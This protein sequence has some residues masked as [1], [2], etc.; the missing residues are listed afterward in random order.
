M[1][2]GGRR[3]E[4]RSDLVLG[5]GPEPPKYA[6]V[7]SQASSLRFYTQYQEYKRST[8]I[9][10]S[11]Q[12][13]T[14]PLLSVTQLLPV[15]IR[16]CLSRTYFNGDE[17][18]AD[19]LW[20]ALAKHAECW[21]DDTVDH[22]IA[23]AEVARLVRMGNER[24][25][26]D[27]VDAAQSRLETYFEN[28]SV[29]RVFRDKTQYK[30][31]PASI[32]SKSLV[33][34]LRPPE[35]KVKVQHELDMRS[36]WKDKPDDVF[37]VVRAA[38]LDWRTVELADKRRSD[39]NGGTAGSAA[40]K[41]SSRDSRKEKP[42]S[43]GGTPASA[44]LVTCFE[45]KKPGHV[46]RNCPLT[47]FPAKPSSQ[48]APGGGNTARGASAGR[49]AQQQQ[50]QRSSSQGGQRPPT[51]ST[52]GQHGSQVS[53]AGRGYG[54]ASASTGFH[55][56]QVAGRAVFSGD[57]GA[58]G[59][60]S[61][62]DSL[63]PPAPFPS[64][65]TAP[66]AL[67]AS[68]HPP[69]PDGGFV[70]A[71]RGVKPGGMCAFE[72][73]G[74]AVDAHEK[75]CRASLSVPGAADMVA[76]DAVAV[77]DSGSGLTTMSV[78]VARK[79]QEAYP[80]VRI[81]E[82]MH[83]PGKLKVA[84]GRVREVTEKTIP[85][86]IALHTSWG[87][88][89]LDPFSFAVMPGDDDVLILGNPTLK[90]L[91][92]DVYDS[93][94]ATAREQAKFTGVETA[95]YKQC[96][97]VVLS[98]DAL[99]QKEDLQTDVPD[100]AVERLIA[101]GPDMCMTSDE[102]TTGRAA[103]LE[104]AVSAAD[105]AGLDE[106]Y[107]ERL[108]GIIRG[109]WN[110]FRR[111]L[112]QGDPPARV[113]PLKVTLTSDARP[114]KARPRVYNPVKTAWLASCMASLVALGL[115]FFNMQAVW[116]SAALVI[117]KKAGFRLVS[118]YRQVNAQVE[119]VPAV[120]PNQEAS[121]AKLSEARFYGS[122]DMLQ[123]YWQ[124]PLAPEA[125]EIFTIATPEGLFTP[126]RVPQGILN[127]TSF[128]QATL[129]QVLAGLNCMVWVD[130]VVYW[131]VDEDDLLDTLDK[132]LARLEE[133]GMFVAAHKCT[134]FETSITWCGKVYSQGEVK[135]DSDRL[136]GLA[137]MRRPE[138]AGE[139][140]QFL[141]AVNW[142]RTSLPRMAEVVWPLRVFLEEQMA[143][144]R[145]RTKRVAQNRAI[146]TAAWTPER[147]AAWDA[148]QALVASAVTLSHP[149]ADCVVLMFPDASDQHYGSFLT[150]VPED[151]VC[152]C[153]PV[154]DMTHEP[155]GFLSGTFR[156][157]Q[158]RWATVDK[159]G[160]A[161]VSTFK[162]LEYLLWNGVHIYTDHRN[163]AYIFDPE[164]CVSSVAKTRAQRLDQWKAVLGQ[165]S[166]TIM[167]IEGERNCWGDL[168]SRWVDVPSV[169]VR[170]VAVYA[171]SEPDDALPSKESIRDAQRAS[172]A[173][174]GSLA[175][176]A[177]SF[178]AESGKVALDGEGLFR[179]HLDGRDV[180][181]IPEDAKK[182]QTRLMVCAHMKD[183]GH[184]GTV[185]TLHRLSEYCCWFRMEEHVTE[186]VKQCLHCMDSKAGEKVPRPLGETVHGTRPGEVVHVDYLFVGE[187]GPLGGDGLDEDDGYKYILV[188]LDDMSNWVWLE[189]TGACTARVTAQHLMAWCKTLGVPE[190]F[191]SDTASHFKNHMMAALEKSLGI[192]RKF[193]VANSPWSN[194]T[195]ERMMREVV[196][197]LK[198]MLQE[199]RRSTRDWVDLV[200]A[201]QWALNTA[202]RERYGS[203][204][205][206][207]MFGRA[208]RIVFLTLASSTE[209]EWQ[210]DVL[211]G[212]A[213][214]RQVRGVVEAQANLHKEVLEKVQANRG[215]Q[216]A[217]ATKGTLPNF[218]VGDYVLVARVRRSGSTPKL[219]MT[220]TGPWR[221]VVA[222]HPHVYGVQNIVSGEVRDVHV[223]RLRFYAD[224]ALAITAEVK[225]V[226]QHAFT[227][228]EFEMAAIVDMSEA[229]DGPGF[230]VEVE[231][232]GF[233]KS[234]NTWEALSKIWDAS[235]QFV[236]SELRKLGLKKAVRAQ[237]KAQ[238]GI[239]L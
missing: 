54:G 82:G 62:E 207:V 220:W 208:P 231:W 182:L 175:A 169:S 107:V 150:Q 153:V 53:S 201:V 124:L 125:Q 49:S 151:E 55:Q 143:G 212:Q 133:A 239:A 43:G 213:L 161:I 94:G 29:E 85:V 122:L 149:R 84:D 204:P 189:P 21:E 181:W 134:F 48:T 25:A 210:V 200:P 77:L 171:P 56:R 185:A 192:D 61:A 170:A 37:D 101:R 178:V 42:K 222:E 121:M 141:Q 203:T 83:T 112:R 162:R 8:E 190:V 117:P 4:I 106:P 197:T 132:I 230:D 67:E 91:G 159:E 165:Y 31:G 120:M 80:A 51:H 2:T 166:Y 111:G 64:A 6:R 118:D 237:L 109:R 202:Y 60:G 226:F 39:A 142:L 5:N 236:K 139:L 11:G 46:A 136:S 3:G 217:A 227:Q 68:G 184:R 58:P 89:S 69:E 147:V 196:R 179:V 229:E 78:G 173:S 20:E 52:Q 232:V 123:G 97:R 238:Y 188:M 110:V 74:V 23:A 45:C 223:A 216:R 16:R 158:Q 30:K 156:G 191:V 15:S 140:M 105:K 172:R 70:P 32:I 59:A 47:L 27:R 176:P 137:N 71:Y 131:G 81:V 99:Q 34:G 138:T 63:P 88:V 104:D 44:D 79:L 205:Y 155:L 221:V 86:R 206:H 148:A 14:R 154:E 22:S 146:P 198:A 209:S 168:L 93:L 100:D 152:R 12:S 214:R 98:V 114:V 129:T 163:L 13:I 199:E 180:L 7:F 219:L 92:I 160:F 18:E 116:A 73:E 144:A 234:E 108:R 177:T 36:G 76:V 157:A 195:C 164:A 127:A 17:L 10:N 66:A 167:H 72:A 115:V 9:C 24:T 228:G 90:A 33:D 174:L 65:E 145:N 186:F 193:A 187:S 215:R 38:A 119:Q 95:A 218:A 194:G 28:P 102:E 126:T 130:D 40:R 225:D 233:D 57:V 75:W 235:P 50:Q 26:T 96:R 128:F 41:S 135:H 87:L 19:D 103:A 1:S 211:D 35:F 183:A 224:S 113:E